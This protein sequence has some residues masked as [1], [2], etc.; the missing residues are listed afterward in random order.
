M[1]AKAKRAHTKNLMPRVSNA[2]QT[3][4]EGDKAEMDKGWEVKLRENNNTRT[5]LRDQG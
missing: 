3:K 5:R 1:G 2:D 4:I